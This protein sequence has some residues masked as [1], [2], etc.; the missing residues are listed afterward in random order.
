MAPIFLHTLSSLIPSR[1]SIF[2]LPSGVGPCSN[3]QSNDL[4]TT[5]NRIRMSISDAPDILQRFNGD[6]TQNTLPSFHLGHNEKFINVIC[7]LQP[8]YRRVWTSQVTSLIDMW[9]QERVVRSDLEGPKRK[10]EG[11]HPVAVVNWPIKNYDI[12]YVNNLKYHI[13]WTLWISLN[14]INAI[15]NTLSCQTSHE[16]TTSLL[17]R[18]IPIVHEDCQISFLYFPCSHRIFSLSRSGKNGSTSYFTTNQ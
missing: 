1:D 18:A 17:Q 3:S 6:I 16:S 5:D 7:I 9:R 12:A 8:S 4:G 15:N 10:N 2:R 11:I 13:C 14:T